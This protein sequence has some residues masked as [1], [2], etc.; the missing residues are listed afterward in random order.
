MSENHILAIDQGTS[1][2]KTIIFDCRGRI[3]AKATQPLR[4]GFPQPGFVE[5][6]PLEIYQNVLNS[7]KKSLKEFSEKASRSLNR[8]VRYL[9]SK[10]NLSSLGPFGSA[11]FQCC[12]LAV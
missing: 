3:V 12:C 11:P 2:T 6:N 1:G 8:M 10:R 5:Q 9:Q 7:T 4:S